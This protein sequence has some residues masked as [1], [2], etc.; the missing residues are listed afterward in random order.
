MQA[1]KEPKMT[2]VTTITDSRAPMAYSRE[3]CAVLI[4][5][6]VQTI[7]RMIRDGALRAVRYGRRVFVPE[8]AV[9]EFLGDSK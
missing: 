5:C 1:G 2:R 8:N 4:H 9:R 7:D 6:D 3:E